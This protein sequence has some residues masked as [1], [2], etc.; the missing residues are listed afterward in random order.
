MMLEY[1]GEEDAAARLL[2]AI[3]KVVKEKLNSL[4]PGRMGYSTKKVGDLVVSCLA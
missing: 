3:K 2:E 4:D 1:L